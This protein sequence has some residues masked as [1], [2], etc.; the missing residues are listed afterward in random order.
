MP[1]TGGRSRQ[2]YR[3][4]VWFDGSRYNTLGWTADQRHL[5]FVHQGETTGSILW[6]VP[7]NGG[8]AAKVGVSMNAR[9]NSPTVHPDGTRIAFATVEADTNEVWA[10]ENFFPPSLSATP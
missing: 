6:R 5:L 4:N 1:A 9:I 3:A 2:V 10:L 7:V 8:P